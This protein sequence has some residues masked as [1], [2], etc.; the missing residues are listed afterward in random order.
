MDA[1]RLDRFEDILRDGL[2]KLCHGEGLCP[3]KLPSTPDLEEAWARYAKPYMADAVENFNQYPEA[4]LA[5]AA[6]L[7]MGVAHNWDL[8]WPAHKNDD[9]TSYYGPRGRKSPEPSTAVRLPLWDLCAT[10]A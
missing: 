9:Y 5:W 7:G 10:R 3:D 8:D 2:V 6:F 4:A 1:K